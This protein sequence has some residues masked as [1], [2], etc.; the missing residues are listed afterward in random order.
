MENSNDEAAQATDEHT[1][2]EQHLSQGEANSLL[3]SGT[4]AV[5]KAGL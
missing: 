3:Y 2:R 1:N 5:L 4:P